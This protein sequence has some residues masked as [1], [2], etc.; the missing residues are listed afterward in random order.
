MKDKRIAGIV[1]GQPGRDGAGVNLTRVLHTGTLEAF[2]PFL[3]LD[4]FDSKDPAD[5]INGF[6]EHP[7]RGIETITYL[8]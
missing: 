6:P 4:S 2:D 5:Y 7:H 3:M 1:R 8:A